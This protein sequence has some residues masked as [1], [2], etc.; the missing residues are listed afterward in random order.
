[1]P[2]LRLKPHVRDTSP[3]ARKIVHGLGIV[4]DDRNRGNSLQ[5]NGKAQIHRTV[6]PA[7]V[8]ATCGEP[9]DH[10]RTPG[11][12]MKRERFGVPDIGASFARD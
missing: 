3:V 1:M 12:E 8:T 6:K 9:S 11:A 5:F 2:P 7:V 10:T 4:A